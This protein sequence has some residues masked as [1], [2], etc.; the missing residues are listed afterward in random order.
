MARTRE[1]ACDRCQEIANALFRIQITQ[2]WQ[3]I[4]RPCYDQ[5][6]TAHPEARY[7]G[8]WKAKKRD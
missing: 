1:K 2:D 6:M 5:V 3:L 4:C 8:T 7:G